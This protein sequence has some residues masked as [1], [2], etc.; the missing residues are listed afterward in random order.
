MNEQFLF[1]FNSTTSEPVNIPLKEGKVVFVVGANGVGKSSLMQHLH[2]QNRNKSKR[3]LAHRKTWFRSN[4]MEITAAS[5]KQIEVNMMSS[6]ANIQSRWIDDYY[7]QRST[8]SIFDLIDSENIRARNIATAVDNKDI[9]TAKAL[10][11]NEAPIKTIN[12]LLATANI[13]VKINLGQDDQLFA[14]KNGNDH[15]SIAELSDGERNALLI[16][17]DVLTAKSGLL[18]IID[19]PER[20]LHRSIVS[21]LLS[22]LFQKR[23]DCAFVIS[24]HD[25]FLPLDNPSSSVLMV[26]GSTWSGKTITGWD[27]DLITA[28]ENI[29]QEIK[30][31]ILGAKR[32]ILFIEGEHESLDRQIYQLIYPDVS[33]IPQGNCVNVERAVEGIKRT[34]ELHWINAFGLIDVDDRTQ[35]QIQKL[36]EKGIFALSCYS[37][38]SLY[39]HVEIINKIAHR[40]A[41]TTGENPVDLIDKALLS[42]IPNISK[43]KDRLSSRLSEKRIRSKIIAALPTHKD[44]INQD[45]F[46]IEIDLKSELL[47][48]KVIFEKSVQEKDYNSLIS[49]YPVRETEVLAKISES[50]G[51][52]D[53]QKYESA[54][55]KLIID[56][57]NTLS[58]FR[59]LLGDLSNKLL[60]TVNAIAKV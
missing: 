2:T 38:E 49:R 48:E 26:R 17:T 55:R 14:T 47:K 15:Y 6:D 36:I 57:S 28:S 50:L 37:V 11:C 44:I 46:S 35:E 3:I 59:S 40:V 20:H 56:D 7:E 21:P 5:K 45:K 51:F 54:V 34:E 53:R 33:V 13:P 60:V 29:S 31:D 25:V 10:S 39:Y 1:S 12:E 9:D 22:S 43:H 19:E 42:I 30:K 4:A 27:A 41:N 58:F 16:A 52:Q 18:I 23:A 32:N 24:T 8:L